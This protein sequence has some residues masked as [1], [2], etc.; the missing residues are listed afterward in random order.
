VT[1]RRPTLVEVAIPMRLGSIS[2]GRFDL[3]PAAI[4]DAVDRFV[5]HRPNEPDRLME[6]GVSVEMHEDLD[7]VTPMTP[8]DAFEMMQRH[9]GVSIEVDVG[10]IQPDRATVVLGG[11]NSVTRPGVHA[12]SSHPRLDRTGLLTLDAH[13]DLRDT[14]NGLNNGN[15]VRALLEDGLPG[16]NIVQIGIQPFANSKAYADVA[17]DAGITVVTADEARHQGV[18]SVVQKAL[19]ELARRVDAIYVDLD[20]DVLDRAFAPAAPGSRP[21]GLSPAEVQAAARAAG[22]HPKVR[23]MDIVE[24]DPTK[25]VADVTVLAAASFLLSFAAGL[26]ARSSRG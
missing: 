22:A 21:G 7:A 5:A 18:A 23:V 1:E 11:D 6:L 16:A 25:D 14:T 19:D 20:V 15:P 12:A 26:A 3:A 13:H 4:R 10:R 2:G 24:V 17:Y 9:I 8:S